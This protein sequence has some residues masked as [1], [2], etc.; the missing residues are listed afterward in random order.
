MVFYACCDLVIHRVA[1]L[2]LEYEGRLIHGH[3]PIRV[4]GNV[5]GWQSTPARRAMAGLLPP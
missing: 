1:Q 2:L 3:A 4:C 5:S